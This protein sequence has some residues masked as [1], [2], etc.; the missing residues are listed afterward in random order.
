MVLGCQCLTPPVPARERRFRLRRAPRRHQPLT[1]TCP[2]RPG[3]FCAITPTA[4]V[5]PVLPGRYA[6][7]VRCR[8]QGRREYNFKKQADAHTRAHNPAVVV[9]VVPGAT[10]HS[11]ED[12]AVVRWI[13]GCMDD[14]SGVLPAGAAARLYLRALVNA[15]SRC[16]SPVCAAHLPAARELPDFADH[17]GAILEARSRHRAGAA[18][19]GALGGYC[20]A[21]VLSARIDG[22]PASE[23]AERC[24]QEFRTKTLDLSPVR[25][26]KFRFASRPAE[27]PLRHRAVCDCSRAGVGV[28]LRVRVVRNLLDQLRLDEAATA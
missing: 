15:A 8:P 1:S 22:A 21:T 12:P 4:S 24:D 14:L 9:P 18:D 28:E 7:R 13:G 17:P 25:P 27:L 5:N 3:A 10:D 11:Q 20:R 16:L 19:S 2:S 26:I 6:G 23:M